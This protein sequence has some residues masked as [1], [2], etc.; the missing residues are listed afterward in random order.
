MSE[1]RKDGGEPSP[2]TEIP[3]AGILKEK[4]RRDL[5]GRIVETMKGLGTGMTRKEL[6][7]LARQVETA[8]NLEDLKRNLETKANIGKDVP[9]EVLRDLFQLFQEVR[10]IAESDLR[11]LK[12]EIGRTNVMKDYEADPGANFSHRFPWVKRL[13]DTELGKSVVIDVQGFLVGAA[14]SL[15]SAVSLLLALI[16]DLFLLPKHAIEARRSAKSEK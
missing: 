1:T 10:E 12:L 6:V 4:E 3:S 15:I 9:E 16:G 13:E 7:A 14:D 8:K 11:E 2:R 5:E